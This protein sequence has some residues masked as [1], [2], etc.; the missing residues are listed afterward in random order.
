M[1]KKKSPNL[2]EYLTFFQKKNTRGEETEKKK[3][4]SREGT[5][6]AEVPQHISENV[7]TF[8]EILYSIL[9]F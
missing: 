2:V 1:R 7:W 4:T 3:D 6:E 5:W 9:L 8:T